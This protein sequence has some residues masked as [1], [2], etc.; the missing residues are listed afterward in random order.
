VGIGC[1]VTLKDAKQ[2]EIKYTILGA[3]DGDPK[4][5]ILSYQTPLANQLLGKK[6]GEFVELPPAQKWRIDSITRWTK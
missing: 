3:W 5:N 4:R 6:K 2:K 1:V